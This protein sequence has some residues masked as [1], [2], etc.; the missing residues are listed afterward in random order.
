MSL[1]FL[2]RAFLQ[3]HDAHD[4]NLA[5]IILMLRF[6]FHSFDTQVPISMDPFPYNISYYASTSVVLYISPTSP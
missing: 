2:M 6:G 1:A 4:A 5:K 3:L